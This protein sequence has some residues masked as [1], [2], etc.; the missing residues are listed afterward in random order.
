MNY[1]FPFRLDLTKINSKIQIDDIDGY[2]T[3]FENGKPVLKLFKGT[4]TVTLV[5]SERE[6]Y[7]YTRQIKVGEYL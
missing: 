1:K 3:D 7:D 6:I 2:T 5:V 4:Q